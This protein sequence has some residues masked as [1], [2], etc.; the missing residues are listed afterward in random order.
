MIQGLDE[1]LAGRKPLFV[2]DELQHYA[3]VLEEAYSHEEPIP[4]T[5]KRGRPANPKKVIDGDLDYATVKKM[6]KK[7][8]IVKVDVA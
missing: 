7:G 4:L 5:G 1:S 6:R 3:T 8:S 2:S